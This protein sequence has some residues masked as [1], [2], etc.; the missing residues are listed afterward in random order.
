MFLEST[1]QN[2][3]RISLYTKYKIPKYFDG[4]REIVGY[5]YSKGTHLHAVFCPICAKDPEMYGDG[6]F[7]VTGQYKIKQL[8]PC[9]CARYHKYTETQF[10]ILVK[11]ELSKPQH[12]GLSFVGL[13]EEFNGYDTRFDVMCE[14]HGIFNTTL[15]NIRYKKSNNSACTKC[16]GTY[17]KTPEEYT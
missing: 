4:V 17:V 12:K 5:S 15:D 2:Q 6:I 16:S 14:T 9:G 11:R 13:S 3:W 1:Q 10:M 7:L 8:L